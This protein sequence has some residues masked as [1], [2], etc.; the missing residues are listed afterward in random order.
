MEKLFDRSS[1][2]CVI[3]KLIYNKH[4]DFPFIVNIFLPN[5]LIYAIQFSIHSFNKPNNI[6]AYASYII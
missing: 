5:K 3:N 1:P 6:V 2:T 4:F